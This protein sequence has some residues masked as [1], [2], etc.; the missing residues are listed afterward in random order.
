MKFRRCKFLTEIPDISRS[1]NLEVLD[2][3]CC[4]SLVKVHDSVGFLDKLTNLE[5]NKCSNLITLPRTLKLRSLEILKFQFCARLQNLPKIGCKMERLRQLAVRW[6]AIKE[7]P[8]SIVYFTG[9]SELYIEGCKN[10]THLPSSLQLQPVNILRHE[11]CSKVV[12]LPTKV[13]DERES[14]L[15]VVSTEESKI[16]SSTKLFASPPPAN[17]C[18]FDDGSSSI[19]FPALAFLSIGY[20]RG[21][22][23]PEFIMTLDRFSSLQRLHL[24]E[25]DI[26]RLPACIKRFVGLKYLDLDDCKQLKEIPELPPNIQIIRA[27]RCVSLVSFPEISK[28]YQFNTSGLGEENWIDLSGCYKLAENIG[29]Q[30]ENTLLD[31]VCL[32]LSLSLF[33][34]CTYFYVPWFTS[35]TSEK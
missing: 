28:M 35:S 23:K 32:S 29:N 13:R 3:N 33:L 24:S 4:E 10:L 31:K 11:R 15:S 20:C 18:I 16:S 27:N 12:K 2:V 7:L 6:I 22:V 25:T 26:V 19:V 9:L 5:F 1:P 30:V 21:L 14:M 34:F 8:S 17:A